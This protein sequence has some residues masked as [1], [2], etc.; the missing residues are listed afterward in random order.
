MAAYDSGLVTIECTK[1]A[2]AF[3][4]W[5]IWSLF[6]KQLFADL[7]DETFATAQQLYQLLYD[8]EDFETLHQPQ[9]NIVAFRYLPTWLVAETPERISAFQRDLRRELIHSGE[10][11]IVQ[12][13]L[14]G[15]AALRVTVM[16]PLTESSHCVDLLDA[17]RR[18]GD[19]L[20]QTPFAGSSP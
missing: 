17:I 10:F 20:R 3:G 9:C 13:T 8:S 12:T 2:A 1:R 11:Y 16:N 14:D 15:Q 19:K 18:T 5:G 7:V 4:L 6:G